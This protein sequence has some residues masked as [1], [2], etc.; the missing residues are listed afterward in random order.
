MMTPM[1]SYRR[2]GTQEMGLIDVLTPICRDFISCCTCLRMEVSTYDWEGTQEFQQSNSGSLGKNR[3]EYCSAVPGFNPECCNGER[4]ED[5]CNLRHVWLLRQV[6]IFRRWPYAAS[7]MVKSLLVCLRDI[8]EHHG[9]SR[10]ESGT[11]GTHHG[12]ANSTQAPHSCVLSWK[13]K[14]FP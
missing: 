12:S 4:G 3:P 13:Q 14:P 6:T 10:D 2:Q 8:T 11:V 5:G 7:S 9:K 1:S